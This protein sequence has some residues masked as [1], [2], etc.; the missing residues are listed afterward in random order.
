MEYQLAQQFKMIMILGKKSYCIVQNLFQLFGNFW[1]Q[2]SIAEKI[3]TAKDSIR[4]A[5]TQLGNLFVC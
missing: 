4:I 2:G 3:P 1:L 5:P